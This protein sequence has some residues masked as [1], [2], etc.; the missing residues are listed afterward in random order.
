MFWMDL[1]LATAVQIQQRK[2]ISSLALFPIMDRCTVCMYVC[3]DG[4]NQLLTTWLDT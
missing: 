4:S 1:E 2:K 3:M